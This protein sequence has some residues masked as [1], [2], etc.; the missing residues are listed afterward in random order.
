[1]SSGKILLVEDDE[2]LRDI[3]LENL[4][5]EG[6]VVDTAVDGEEAF[7]KAKADGYDLVL[8][9]IIL[10]KASGLDV[11]RQI[12]A[13][14][15]QP[16]NRMVIFLTNLDK[17]EEIKEALTL[18]DGYLIKSQLTPEDML[19]EVNMYMGKAK[20]KQGQTSAVQQ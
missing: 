19:R 16:T 13:L 20:E 12:K 1:M 8:M 15:Q 17:E 10:P 14:P 18:G 11:M 7:T 3:Y 4:T 2:F 9:D 6:Y 5:S